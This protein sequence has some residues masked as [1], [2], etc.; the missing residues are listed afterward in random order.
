MKI[1]EIESTE[2]MEKWSQKYKRSIDCQHPKGFSQRAH[3][4]GRKKHN[5]NVK[6]NALSEIDYAD[7]L[8]SSTI[9][10]DILMKS[11]KVIGNIEGNDVVMISKGDHTVYILKVDD[12]ASAFIGFDGKNLKNIKNFTDSSGVIRAL[13]G[14]LIHKKNMK[15]T[16]SPD[17]PLTRDGLKWIIRLISEP[18][19]LVVKDHTGND[20]DVT[21]LKQEWQQ[22]KKTGIPGTTGL[23]ISES[24]V[25]GNKLR[26][27]ELRRNSE[28]LLMPYNF[29][30][31]GTQKQNMLEDSM[32]L[33]DW[34]GKGKHGGA[35]GGGWDRYNTKGE[36]IGKCGDRKPGEGK[37][38][39]LSKAK[40]ASLRA[41]GG[42]RA[43]AAAVNKKRREDPNP[44]RE[45]GAK[46]VSNRTRS[47]K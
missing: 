16:I 1:S 11:G 35:S 46:M 36:R 12:K 42:K 47:K 8:D 25:F 26:E 4:Q 27:N 39:C 43:I 34:F 15:I 3:C 29:Y 30:S 14:Y 21:K 38:K 37:P 44:N 41:S 13:I 7:V 10:P 9:S 20:I 18:Q 19:G 33:H 32:S 45:G 17:E 6:E 28:S 31:I 2:L 22:A 40:A 24:T 5:K 23:I